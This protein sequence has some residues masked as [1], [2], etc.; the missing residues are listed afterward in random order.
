ML[1]RMALCSTLTVSSLS[2]MFKTD[3]DHLC[4]ACWWEFFCTQNLVDNECIGG[5]FCSEEGCLHLNVLFYPTGQTGWLSGKDEQGGATESGS[6][7][8]CL[9]G[10]MPLQLVILLSPTQ[11]AKVVPVY[12]FFCTF[13]VKWHPRLHFVR[14]RDLPFVSWAFVSALHRLSDTTGW[15]L[16]LNVLFAEVEEAW[17]MLFVTK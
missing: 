13:Q 12:F 5:V 4:W 9:C 6:A 15:Q 8:R 11:M 1:V 16:S 17:T 3:D 2:V 7:G 10:Q 14:M